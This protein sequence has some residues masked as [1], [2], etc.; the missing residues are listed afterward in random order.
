MIILKTPEEIAKMRKAGKAVAEVLKILQEKIKPG[1]TTANLNA[2]AEY[3]CKKRGAIPVFKNYPN[4]RKGPPFPG[5][6][7]TSVNDEV[8]HGVPSNRVL[9]EGDIISID[10][11]VM[12]DG[13]AGD[14]AITVP[15]GTVKPEVMKLLKVTEEA[16]YKGIE[17][18]VP[19]NRLG[20]VS[21]T[22]QVY[23]EKH[24]FSVVREFVGHGIGRNMH[25][26]PPVPNFGRKDRGPVLKAGMTLAIEPMLNMGTHRVYTGLDEW[27]VITYDHSYSAHFEHTVAITA[28]GPEILTARE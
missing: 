23:A 1:I 24:G 22:I 10:F 2:I 15:V 5:V 27:T 17:K 3:E 14:S 21:N 16:L 19:G 11:G 26:D 6:I 20:A 8:V 7:C 28:D 9:E 4:P 18:A 12:L 13:Y 25:E